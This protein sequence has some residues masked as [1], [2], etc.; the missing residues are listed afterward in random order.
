MTTNSSGSEE[1]RVAYNATDEVHKCT[2]K[3]KT[4]KEV[5]KGTDE[6]QKRTANITTNEDVDKGNG[7]LEYMKEAVVTIRRKDSDNF[8]GRFK[9]YTGW[10]NPDHDL[11][12]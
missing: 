9:V 12:K 1:R 3:F 2:E 10:F 7:N 6:V 8:E 5:V 4:S 11:K